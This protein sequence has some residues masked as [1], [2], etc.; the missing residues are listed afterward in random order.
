LDRGK[1]F[2][3]LSSRLPEELIVGGYQS[4]IL[5]QKNIPSK[6]LGLEEPVIMNY[7]FHSEDSDILAHRTNIQN[8]VTEKKNKISGRTGGEVVQSTY[9]WSESPSPDDSKGILR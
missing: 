7:A 3:P 4:P 8:R 9:S 2:P 5:G 1:G 6:K